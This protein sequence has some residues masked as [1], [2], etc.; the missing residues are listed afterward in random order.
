MASEQEKIAYLEEHISYEVVMLNYT[1][2]RLLTSKPSTAE[3]QLDL[4]AYLRIIWGARP[5][6]GRIS[7]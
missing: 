6:L 3:Q 7:F 2:M 4:N 5:E 1:F